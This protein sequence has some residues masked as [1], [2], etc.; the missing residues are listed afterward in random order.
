[1]EKNVCKISGLF[2]G[3]KCRS[4]ETK[5]KLLREFSSTPVLEFEKKCWS[6]DSKDDVSPFFVC[7]ACGA[8]QP[9]DEGLDFFQLLSM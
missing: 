1:L 6:C 4:L 3:I 8:I 2:F 7:T 9:L 5:G